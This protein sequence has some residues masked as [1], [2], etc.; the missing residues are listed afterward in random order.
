MAETLAK[1]VLAAEI[2]RR[3]IH[4]QAVAR[5]ADHLSRLLSGPTDRSVLVAA[6]W[7]H[8]VGYARKIVDTGFHALDGARWLRSMDID[9]RVVALVAYHSCAIF[10]AQERGLEED[11]CTEF[12]DETSPLRDALWFADMTTGPDGQDLGV[13]ERLA[14]IRSRYGPDHLVTRF[15]L[16]AEPE[17]LAV[18]RRT[19]ER[20]AA[21]GYQPM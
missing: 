8:D 7:L 20:M 5:K 14:E 6:A 4:V 2:P 15:W 12:S 18:V 16:R 9:E 11:L 1:S 13:I 21:A 3:W 17:L 19:E 10:E